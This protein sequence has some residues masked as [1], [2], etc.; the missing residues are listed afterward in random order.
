MPRVH[1]RAAGRRAT[2]RRATSSRRPVAQVHRAAD[3][4]ARQVPVVAA[5]SAATPCT[6][7]GGSA[8]SGS[9]R[10]SSPTIDLP[11]RRDVVRVPRLQRERF[12]LVRRDEVGEPAEVLGERRRRPG[13]VHEQPA[14]PDL[15]R[16]LDQPVRRACRRPSPI[17][18]RPS[19][20]R[21]ARTTSRGTGRPPPAGRRVLARRQQLVAAVP[22]HVGERARLVPERRAPPRCR[23]PS[24]RVASYRADSSST[25]PR[26]V[27]LAGEQVPPFPRQHRG[28]GVRLAAAAS[29]TH[30]AAAARPP[31]HEYQPEHSPSAHYQGCTAGPSSPVT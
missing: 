29:P 25:R 9:T 20:R 4:R 26:H 2:G 22:A 6:A 8:G 15:G 31:T 28:I 1:A 24:P 14:V 23:R 27:Q 5:R 7:R 30:H 11:V 10:G 21:P 17:R 16:Q 18:G 12:R 13:R 19:P 3:P